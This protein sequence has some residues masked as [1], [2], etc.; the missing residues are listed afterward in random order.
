MPQ[1]TRMVGL[2]VVATAVLISASTA[3]TSTASSDVRRP[4]SSA[5]VQATWH[6]SF[7]TLRQ[8]TQRAVLRGRRILTSN[9]AKRARRIGNQVR[10]A[11][12]F[13]CG[14]W[15]DYFKG[16]PYW[17]E[18]TSAAVRVWSFSVEGY[19]AAR[20]YLYCKRLAYWAIVI[21]G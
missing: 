4:H 6:N 17:A 1:R 3:A 21:Y 2:V 15:V 16:Y 14:Q 7:R 11:T 8:L 5:G 12:N 13:Y 10:K 20:A 9:E 18:G 19:P